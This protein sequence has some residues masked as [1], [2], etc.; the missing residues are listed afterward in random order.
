MLFHAF[1]DLLSQDKNFIAPHLTSEIADH[2][3]S[4][5]NNLDPDTT[6]DMPDGGKVITDY[7]GHVKTWVDKDGNKTP[8]GLKVL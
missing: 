5:R 1:M 4:G 7:R 8:N 3:L 2:V 6:Y